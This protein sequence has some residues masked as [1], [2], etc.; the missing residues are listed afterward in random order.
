MTFPPS[1]EG[2]VPADHAA[3]VYDVLERMDITALLQ[4]YRPEG[5]S[6]YHPR[7]LLCSL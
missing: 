1:L 3:R 2:L 6:S 4:Q 5:T 7:M